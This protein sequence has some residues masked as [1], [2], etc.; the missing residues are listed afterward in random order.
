MDIKKAIV[1]IGSALMAT[2]L[3]L[4]W[5]CSNNKAVDVKK[6]KQETFEACANKVAR[7][8]GVYLGSVH[9]SH[10][11]EVVKTYDGA[12]NKYFD[13]IDQTVLPAVDYGHSA[14]PMKLKEYQS[15]RPEDKSIL[16][17]FLACR[18]MSYA[19]PN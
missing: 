1:R 2:S 11:E 7:Q 15:M 12:I 13:L 3:V 19:M 17:G 6:K 9:F 8:N 10:D 16:D 5:G 4:I 18:H 14:V